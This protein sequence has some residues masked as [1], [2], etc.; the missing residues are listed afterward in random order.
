M[1]I[2]AEMKLVVLE[3]IIM[4]LQARV[5]DL[6]NART[7]ATGSLARRN[8]ALRRAEGA[9]LRAEIERILAAHPDFSAKH[10]LKALA[11]VDLGRQTPPSVRVVQWHIQAVRNTRAALRSGCVPQG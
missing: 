10:V 11:S 5:L 8:N 9:Q 6:E 3:G 4:A 2:A 1:S 7:P